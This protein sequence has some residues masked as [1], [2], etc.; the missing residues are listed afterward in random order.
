MSPLSI[1]AGLGP[2]ML[3]SAA[4]AGAPLGFARDRSR[5]P[6][7]DMGTGARERDLVLVEGVRKTAGALRLPARALA[8]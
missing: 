7:T 6:Y 1:A 2:V 3:A 5:K 4:L 8:P